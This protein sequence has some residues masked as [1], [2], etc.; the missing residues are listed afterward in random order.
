MGDGF[1]KR[2][3][4]HCKS[5]CI[6]TKMA[7][8]PRPKSQEEEEVS[9]RLKLLE[10][11]NHASSDSEISKGND[12]NGDEENNKG[13][14]GENDDSENDDDKGDDGENDDDKGDDGEND[15]D[16]KGDKDNGKGDDKD[17]GDEDDAECGRDGATVGGLIHDDN[18]SDDKDE[19][20]RR[21]F[22]QR[23]KRQRITSCKV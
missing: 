16:N 18:Y 2:L 17:G 1:E 9:A 23:R 15:D 3:H 11:I 10:S 22:T 14:D 7:P 4:E 21:V 13:D 6:P 19:E 8:K 12:D 20:P 5:I